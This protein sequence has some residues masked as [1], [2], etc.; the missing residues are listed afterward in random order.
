M[1]DRL[2]KNLGK[3]I[4]GMESLDR[5]KTVSITPLVHVVSYTFFEGTN[6]LY[7]KDSF[8][9]GAMDMMETF[10]LQQA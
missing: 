5:Y 6:F 8:P 4:K 10:I 9:K 3:F 1:T 2:L 7:E